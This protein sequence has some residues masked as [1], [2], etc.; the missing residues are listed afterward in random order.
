MKDS[1]KK[2]IKHKANMRQDV[3]GKMGLNTTG[4]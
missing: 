2:E 1:T 4:R 3:N